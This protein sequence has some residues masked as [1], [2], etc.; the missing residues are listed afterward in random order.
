KKIEPEEKIGKEEL[1]PS[2][3]AGREEK[4]EVIKEKI[5]KEFVDEKKKAAESKGFL[6]R[7]FRRKSM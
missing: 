1:K 4:K 3:S 7:V 2:S 5:E 6:K